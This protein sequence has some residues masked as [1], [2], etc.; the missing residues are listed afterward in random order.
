[1]L[2]KQEKTVKELADAI[3]KGED[4]YKRA[5]ARIENWKTKLVSEDAGKVRKLAEVISGEEY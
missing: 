1:M 4:N 3:K 2:L 5:E